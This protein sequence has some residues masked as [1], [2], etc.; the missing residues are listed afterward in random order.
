M[1]RFPWQCGWLCAWLITPLLVVADDSLPQVVASIQE[2]IVKL[3]GAGEGKLE[4]YHTGLLVSPTGHIV[5]VWSYVLDTQRLVVTL[6]DGQRRRAELVGID[7]R[8]ELALLKIPGESLPCFDLEQ[9]ATLQQGEPVLAFSNLYGVAAGDE[10]VSVQQGIVAGVLDL[11]ARRGSFSTPYRGP[12]YVL[13]AIT[14]NPGAAGG[15]LTDRSGRLAG[16]L[17]KEL[18]HEQDHTWLNYALPAEQLRLAVA[19]LLAGRLPV[20]AAAEDEPPPAEHYTPGLIGIELV[21]NVLPNT[22]PFIDRVL[23]GTSAAAAGLAADDLLLTVNGRTVPTCQAVLAA[24]ARV[25]RL[26]EVQL[27]VQR[28]QDHLEVTLRAKPK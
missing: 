7:P 21:P 15:A 16:L 26:D 6:A 27:L 3:Q 13:D 12:V 25:D 20:V 17:G 19:D 24:L 11:A 5:T 10:A 18:R 1:N 22:P 8:R 23:P 4:A 28:G 2:K 14:N 9:G